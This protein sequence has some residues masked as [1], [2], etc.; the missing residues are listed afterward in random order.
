[1]LVIGCL[2]GCVGKVVDNLIVDYNVY[3]V[4]IFEQY[5]VECYCVGEIGLMLFDNY[6][7]VLGWVEMIS[8]VIDEC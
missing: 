1:M 5:C 6:E 3:I 2:I 7:D 8:E 4:L